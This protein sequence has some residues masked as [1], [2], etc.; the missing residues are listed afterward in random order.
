LFTACKKQHFLTKNIEYMKKN[1]FFLIP[2][3]ILV[4]FTASC[5]KEDT[6][7]PPTNTTPEGKWTGTGEY[8]TT[9]GNPTYAFTMTFK[10]NGT[11]DITGDNSTGID[12]ATGTWAL[13][14]DTVKATYIYTGSSASYTL[15]AKFSASSN[16]MVGKIGLTPLT[17]GVGLFTVKRTS[18]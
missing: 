5:S 4:L 1:L 17:T 16:T 9:G 3:F 6:Q 18:N 11:V 8:G 13:V 7:Q 10:A 15:A 2:A 12:V 14:Q